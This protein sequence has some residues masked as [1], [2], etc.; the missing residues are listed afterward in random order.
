MRIPFYAHRAYWKRRAALIP[1]A[2]GVDSPDCSAGC[3]NI[4]RGDREAG[5]KAKTL[6]H[7]S[8]GIRRLFGQPVAFLTARSPSVGD[9]QV[10]QQ[11]TCSGEQE[12]A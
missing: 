10:K 9:P 11:N 5:E 12:V 1:P 2:F 6:H 3:F 4:P 8:A 7:P